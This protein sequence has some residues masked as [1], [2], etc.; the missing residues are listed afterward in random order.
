MIFFISIIE[1][2]FTGISIAWG[3]GQPRVMSSYEFQTSEQGPPTTDGVT[4]K[5]VF[6]GTHSSTVNRTCTE[7]WVCEHRWQAISG[8]LDQS[9]R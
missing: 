4:I 5:S 2:T 6:P 8:K 7:G 1:K 3:Y 9:I